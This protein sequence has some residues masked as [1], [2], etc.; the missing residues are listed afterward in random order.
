MERVGLRSLL[1]GTCA[2]D[3]ESVAEDLNAHL[4]GLA[5]LVAEVY[6][7]TEPCRQAVAEINTIVNMASTR[8]C[9]YCKR[10]MLLFGMHQEEEL[11]AYWADYRD[12]S[13][14]LAR[15]LA[16]RVL[17]FIVPR[18]IKESCQEPQAFVT[19]ALVLADMWEGERLGN[20]PP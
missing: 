13:A 4:R 20:W 3:R 15:D 16:S 1:F 12:D 2:R 11:V 7:D 10:A 9:I 19:L 8:E 5:G 14:E 17:P 6:G 18:F